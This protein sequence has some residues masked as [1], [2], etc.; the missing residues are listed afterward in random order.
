MP[1]GCSWIYSW[2]YVVLVGILGS[3]RQNLCH[4]V[5][6]LRTERDCQ[7]LFE[8]SNRLLMPRFLFYTHYQMNIIHDEGSDT[9][10]KDSN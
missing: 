5:V 8:G 4:D 2:E 1:K 6:K 9:C 3:C 10:E 7:S